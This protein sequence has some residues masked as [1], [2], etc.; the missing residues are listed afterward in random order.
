MRFK[1]K[2]YIL[3]V[4]YYLHIKGVEDEDT[5]CVRDFLECWKDDGMLVLQWRITVGEDP[6]GLLIGITPDGLPYE[7]HDPAQQN[8]FG[9]IWCTEDRLMHPRGDYDYGIVGMRYGWET[10]ENTCF[11]D[12]TSME[13]GWRLKVSARVFHFMKE[14]VEGP[15][16]KQL[17]S[18]PDLFKKKICHLTFQEKLQ[19]YLRKPTTKVHEAIMLDFTQ[20]AD[21]RKVEVVAKLKASPVITHEHLAEI[22][23]EFETHVS[24]E[25]AFPAGL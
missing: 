20:F 22:V 8:A 25:A 12:A 15:K 24:A 1:T 23:E 2:I 11:Q 14:L 13:F 16:E 3:G 9:Y 6:N 10:V 5:G 17:A 18:M 19:R 21:P 7:I 4:P